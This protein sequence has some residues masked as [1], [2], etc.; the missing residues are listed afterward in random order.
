MRKG[1]YSGFIP[2]I[3]K[4]AEYEASFMERYFKIF[5]DILKGI[6][7]DGIEKIEADKLDVVPDLFYPGFTFLFKDRE[8]V[9][10][11][12]IEEEAA[13]NFRKFFRTDMEDFLDFLGGWMGL[14]LNKN[15]DIDTKREMIARIIPLY[16]IRG[17]R[18]GLE[19]Y[20]RISIHNDVEVIEEKE[21]FQVGIISH[22][23]KNTLIGGLPQNY[24]I[25]NITMPESDSRNDSKR[26][27]IEEMIDK[28][29]PLHTRYGLNI[30]Y[31]KENTHVS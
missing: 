5:E 16:R 14:V 18:R 2:S 28:E 13:S 3:F 11:P 31:I 8:K 6:E 4:E 25:V 24:F 23:G 12:G 10:L 26:R 29:K 30:K 20:L 7:N 27:I 15:W 22:V 1:K 19:E 17:T 21:A 9:F